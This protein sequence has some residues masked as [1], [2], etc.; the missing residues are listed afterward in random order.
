MFAFAAQYEMN[1]LS[2]KQR[3]CR[4]AMC[5]SAE[6]TGT[7]GKVGRFTVKQEKIKV[8]KNNPRYELTSFTET[9]T[10]SSL[11]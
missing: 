7:A 6:R 3:T 8:L 1:T 9:P 11:K 10:Y 4:R 5:L 2:P